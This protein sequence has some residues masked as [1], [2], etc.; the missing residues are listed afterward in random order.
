MRYTYFIFFLFLTFW[1]CSQGGD[2]GQKAVVAKVDGKAIYQ[3]YCVACHGA[4][5]RMEINGAKDFTKSEL[6]LEERVHVITNGRNLMQAYKSL[7]SEKE[8][9]AVAQYTMQLSNPE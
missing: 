3:Q 5:G 6:E 2:G 1:A 8:I 4:N 9:K 7:L